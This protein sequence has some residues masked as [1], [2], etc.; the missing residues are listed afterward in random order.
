VVCG[1]RLNNRKSILAD[2]VDAIER[3]IIV[4]HHLSLARSCDTVVLVSEWRIIARAA[5]SELI[6]KNAS[7][8][9]QVIA[10]EW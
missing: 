6:K 8:R 2:F 9:A 10:N 5:F 7:F 1:S 4:T 3:I